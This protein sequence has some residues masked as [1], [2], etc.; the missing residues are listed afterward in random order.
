MNGSSRPLVTFLSSV[1]RGLEEERDNLPAL[2]RAIGH[3]CTRVEDYTARAV[4]GPRPCAR[5][6]PLAPED[7]NG[8][9]ARPK[10]TV[11]DLGGLNPGRASEDPLSLM[12]CRTSYPPDAV[13]A[14]AR[15]WGGRGGAV[16]QLSTLPAGESG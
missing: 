5:L 16:D 10:G 4:A 9:P 6:F 14:H 2:I 8:G 15:A 12:P 13:Q 3:E 7:G 1:R 11:H